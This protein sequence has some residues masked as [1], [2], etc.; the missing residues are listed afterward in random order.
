MATG[1]MG[2]TFDPIHVAHLIVAEAALEELALDRVIFM[3]SASPPH[4]PG[5]ALAPIADRLE[6]VRLAL[7]GNARLFVSDLEARR[8][9]PSYTIDTVLELR[10]ELGHEET[11]YFIMGADN[12]TQFFTWKA[13]E[14][15]LE[16]C[17]FAVVPRPGFDLRD[18]D[19]RI[20]ARAR[21]LNAPMMDVSSSDIRGRVRDGR[22]TR[23]L[24]PAEV[25][26]YIAEKKLYS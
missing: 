5:R 17:E 12:L 14:R 8:P 21:I 6:M 18:A 9:P 4:K 16:E 13:P 15:L 23:Y 7:E 24:V 10:R 20:L 11:L 3:P 2:G 25:S 1:L 26:A 22:T 19:P